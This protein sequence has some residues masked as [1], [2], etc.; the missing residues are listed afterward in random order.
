MCQQSFPVH[1]EG[2]PLDLTLICAITHFN[3]D[4]FW[5]DR[6]KPL[7]ALRSMLLVRLSKDWQGLCKCKNAFQPLWPAWG[8]V[9][10]VR[11]ICLTISSHH[12]IY[13]SIAASICFFSI[14]SLSWCYQFH[15]SF[16][17]DWLW[18]ISSAKGL[19]LIAA[20]EIE[21]VGRCSLLPQGQGCPVPSSPSEHSCKK[22]CHL[23]LSEALHQRNS[24]ACCFI[25]S[26]LP[27]NSKH[28]LQFLG[29]DGP[30]IL[31]LNQY[32]FWS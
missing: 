26:R 17:L 1:A 7:K 10:T 5:N 12:Y 2:L 28:A 14:P 32:W 31:L 9:G 4:I 30:L 25:N 20:A 21:H 6:T 15:C 18:G 3:D 29:V 22:M 23:C 13:P 24:Y 16:V 11:G 27:Q 19:F 8:T